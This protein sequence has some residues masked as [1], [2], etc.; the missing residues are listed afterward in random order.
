MAMMITCKF[1]MSMKKMLKTII[2]PSY[3][4][5]SRKLRRASKSS[6]TSLK[7]KK[8]SSMNLLV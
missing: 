1:S 6:S 8:Q 3:S 7:N 5:L 4:H 2:R